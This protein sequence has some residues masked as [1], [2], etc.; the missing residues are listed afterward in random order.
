VTTNRPRLRIGVTLDGPLV[1]EWIVELLRTIERSD[2]G[3]IA[4]AVVASADGADG[5]GG[6]AGLRTLLYRLYER[7]DWFVF[8]DRRRRRA[9][10]PV[11][12]A[13]GAARVVQAP[14]ASRTV[15]EPDDTVPS[16]VASAHL[17]VLLQLRSE[18]V[19]RELLDLPR[20]GVWALELGGQLAHERAPLFFWEVHRSEHTSPITL[21]ILPGA[22][23]PGRVLYRCQA[24]TDLISPA[25]NRIRALDKAAYHLVRRLQDVRDGAEEYLEF[26]AAGDAEDLR[27]RPLPVPTNSRVVE[28]LGRIAVRAL[29]RLADR[30]LDREHWYIAYRRGRCGDLLMGDCRDFRILGPPPRG[31]SFMDPC[32]FEHDSELYLFFEDLEI[33]K[34]KGAISYV[35]IGE[36]GATA[37]RL[38]LDRPY[39]VSYPFLFSWRGATYL[40]P[41]TFDRK[42]IELYRADPFP[43]RWNL[44]KILMEDIAASDATVLDHGGKLW[45]FVNVAVDG[46]T[47]GD[48][49]FVFWANSP[50]DTWQPH[51]LNPVVADAR[52]ARPAGRIFT[53]DGQ[54]YRPGQDC[55]QRYGGGVVFSRIEALSETDY[56]EVQVGR[57]DRDRTPGNVGAHSYTCGGGYE[58]VD[59]RRRRLGRGV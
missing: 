28:H 41:E 6:A 2:V 22:S 42:T 3:E 4:L 20:Y 8:A 5:R 13:F 9:A 11:T 47:F 10:V 50:T 52:S 27:H 37:P 31:R 23:R 17:D 45:L 33:K 44:E 48:E 51:P 56:R 19:R 34:G 25:R 40:I 53:R 7:L 15:S 24:A 26:F 1:S 35:V 12:T 30:F 29:P 32:L 38:A 39:H 43:E 49:L 46:A 16:A 14:V 18:P 58:A 59:G 21:R 54:L 55:S 57:F 36:N